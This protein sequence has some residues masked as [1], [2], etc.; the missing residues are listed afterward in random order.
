MKRANWSYQSADIRKKKQVTLRNILLF[1][2]V[3]D[4]HPCSVCSYSK[5]VALVLLYPRPRR[6]SPKDEKQ[7]NV[8]LRFTIQRYT[9]KNPF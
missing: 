5:R 9:I 8:E 2:L 6:Q 4:V 1:F 3:R 7:E